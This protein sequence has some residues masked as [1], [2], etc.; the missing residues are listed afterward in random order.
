[1]SRR[2]LFSEVEVID[3]FES[4]YCETV[5]VHQ[6]GCLLKFSTEKEDEIGCLFPKGVRIGEG[7]P[8]LGIL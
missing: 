3:H 4:Y 5:K 1:M 7:L 6:S 8:D 2:E